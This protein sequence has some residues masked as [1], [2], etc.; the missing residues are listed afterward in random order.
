[1]GHLLFY[2]AVG[3]L[4]LSPSH[5]A[6]IDV[7]TFNVRYDNP[8]DGAHAWEHRKERVASIMARADIV[9]VQEALIGQIRDLESMLPTYAWIGV[10]RDDGLRGG[11]FAPIFYQREQFALISEG[12]FW[13]S[14]E[15]HLPGSIGWDAAITRIVTWG[16]LRHIASGTVFWVFNTHFDHRGQE[17]RRQSAQLL[18]ARLDE[19]AYTEPVIVT[20][21]FNAP[22]N[23]VVYRTMT[24]GRLA[25]AR[26]HAQTA[27][28]GPESTFSSFEEG[29]GLPDARIDYVF[30][31]STIAVLAF[32][33]IDEVVAGHYPSD[34]RPVVARLEIR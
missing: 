10:G 24:A 27:P 21:D 16:R 32:E 29:T 31:D 25:D 4:C 7:M 34:H 11:E 8:G 5:A 3:A 30:A 23:S 15:P 26:H 12:T 17:A 14:E 28:L 13:L 18:T 20:G 1:M 2:L 33:V 6:Q 9:G 22:H 19:M